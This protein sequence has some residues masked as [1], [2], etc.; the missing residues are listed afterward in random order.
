MHGERKCGLQIAV[1][2]EIEKSSFY[3]PEVKHINFVHIKVS[4]MD[5]CWHWSTQLQRRVQIYCALRPAKLSLNEMAETPQIDFGCVQRLEITLRVEYDQVRVAE[6]RKRST[7]QQ[8]RDIRPNAPIQRSVGICSSRAINTVA[9][10]PHK[11]CSHWHLASPRSC[12]DTN[13]KSATQTPSLETDP[14][15]LNDEL[16]L[17]SRSDQQYDKRSSKARTT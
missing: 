12:A 9:V 15:S 7:S 3:L 17:C 4:D 6:E 16:R 1:I 2:H 10:A 11:V 5:K 8:L 13:N 14:R